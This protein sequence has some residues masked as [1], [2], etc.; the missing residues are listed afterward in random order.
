MWGGR[1][2][3]KGRENV[4]RARRLGRWAA[5]I[6]GVL[7]ALPAAAGAEKP[8]AAGAGKWTSLFDGKTLDR[9]EVVGRFDFRKHGKVEVRNGNLMLGA[10]QPGTCARFSGKMPKI[11]YELSLEA[12]RVDGED[13]FCGLT[14]PIEEK[15]LSLIVGGWRGPVV[16]LSCIDDE[17]AVENETCRYMKFENKRWYRIRLRVTAR[18]IQVWIDKEKVVDFVPTDRELSIWFERETV[19]PLGIATWETTGAVRKIRVRK[20]K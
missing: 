14:F 18:R 6:G 8:A 13:F 12:M 15:A 1:L 20:I 4:M 17:P 10:G 2:A 3:K 16:G 19:L 11:D 5:V 7:L 9:W